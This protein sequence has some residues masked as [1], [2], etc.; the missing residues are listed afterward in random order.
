MQP[1]G[2]PHLGNYLG[3]MRQH[4]GLSHDKNYEC[5]YFIANYHALTTVRDGKKLRELS[6]ELATDY[7]ALGLDT[8]RTAFFVQSHIPELAEL[9]WIFE[10]ITGMASLDKTLAIIY[11]SFNVIFSSF[12]KL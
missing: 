6:I 11:A 4:I 2:K 7:L 3:A 5:F 12:F 1:S 10:C 8:D 9:A